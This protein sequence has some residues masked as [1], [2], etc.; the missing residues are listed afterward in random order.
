[1]RVASIAFAAYFVSS[2]D[3]D[4]AVR[5]H[6][7]LDGGPLLEEFRIRDHGEGQL[8]AALAQFGRDRPAHFFGGAD[9]HGGFVHHD[10]VLGHVPADAARRRKHM[11]QVRRAVFPGG[12]AHRDALHGSKLHRA[13]DVR[14]ELQPPRGAVA[15][16]DLGEAR[17]EDREPTFFQRADLRL[18]EI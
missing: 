14:R 17:L 6:K 12:R 13:L 9:R 1:M 15:L 18:V 2:A 11:L 10:P 16:D 7:V 4:D 8:D 5:S 3:H